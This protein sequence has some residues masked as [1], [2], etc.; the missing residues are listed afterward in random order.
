MA[1]NAKYF[2]PA[3]DG[4]TSNILWMFADVSFTSSQQTKEKTTREKT[5]NVTFHHQQQIGR[6]KRVKLVSGERERDKKI[7]NLFAAQ[8]PTYGMGTKR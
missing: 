1:L 4:V 2:L 3:I 5:K 8:A 7:V 6:Q